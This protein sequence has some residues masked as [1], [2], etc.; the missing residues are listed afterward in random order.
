MVTR[1]ILSIFKR[2]NPIA[3]NRLENTRSWRVLS[4]RSFDSSL[5]NETLAYAKEEKRILKLGFSRRSPTSSMLQNLVDEGHKVKFCEVRGI[6]KQLIKGRR[7]KNALEILTWM[8]AQRKFRMSAADHAVKM[9]LVIRVHGLAAAQEYFTNIPNT[10]SQKAAYLPLLRSYV[11]ERA[12]EKAECFMLKLNGLG[13]IVSPHPFNEIMKLYMAMSQYEK[14]TLSI[15]QMKRSKIPLNVLSYNLWMSSC[16]EVYGIESAEKVYKE[17]L[18]DKNVEVG[19]STLATLANVYIKSGLIQNANF[20]LREAEK[21]LSNSN[22]LGYF[23]LITLYTSL[24]DKKGV[25]RLWEASK[26]VKGRITC[27]NYMCILS[28]L[29]KLGDLLEAERVFMEWES[30]CFNYDIRVS[31]VLLGAYV[32]NGLMNKAE[33]LHTHTLE[34]GGCPNYKTWEILVEGYIDNQSMDKAVDAMKKGL[35]MLKSCDWRPSHGIVMAIAEYFEKHGDFKG[36]NRYL[37]LIRQLDLASLPVYKSVLRMHLCAQRP[38]LSI[39]KMM[40][41]DE[42]AMDDDASLLIQ[43]I[44]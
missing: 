44:R 9:Q 11:K 38:A 17:M 8:E 25:L 28:S 5:F 37:K 39:I 23:F 40:E 7:Y 12:I 24:K 2:V 34:R 32:R 10:S 35:T 14:V 41:A 26:I 3:L 42:I 18:I 36:M 1:S 6:F 29:V 27:V 20:A 15:I 33:S 4:S 21:K 13:L 31:N 30:K 19:W 43:K 22:H 16:G